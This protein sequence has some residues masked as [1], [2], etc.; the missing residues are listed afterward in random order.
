MKSIDMCVIWIL[1]VSET[2]LILQVYSHI[3]I[4]RRRD[5]VDFSFGSFTRR[6]ILLPFCFLSKLIYKV[7]N[8]MLRVQVIK[9]K[10]FNDFIFDSRIILQ[11]RRWNATSPHCVTLMLRHHWLHSL[12]WYNTRS[13]VIWGIPLTRPKLDVFSFDMLDS[14]LLLTRSSWMQFSVA[15]V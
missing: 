13:H 1:K 5:P 11:A 14:S 3:L 6:S 12:V 7:D 10:L 15:T 2:S 9:S 8:H 4:R